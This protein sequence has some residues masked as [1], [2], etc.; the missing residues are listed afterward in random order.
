MFRRSAGRLCLHQLRSCKPTAFVTLVFYIFSSRQAEK[1][2]IQLLLLLLQDECKHSFFFS[3]NISVC[4][5]NNR[6]F[7]LVK[8]KD[9]ILLEDCSITCFVLLK[10]ILIKYLVSDYFY[11]FH[12]DLQW[13]KNQCLS[14]FITHILLCI[15]TVCQ[16]EAK[17]RQKSIITGE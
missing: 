1:H 11:N 8:Q 13:S 5:W 3:G 16:Y 9:V 6:F 7:S 12:F 10:S 14:V 15:S 4:P 17:K 2:L